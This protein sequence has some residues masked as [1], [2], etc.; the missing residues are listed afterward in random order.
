MPP[1]PAPPE[2][3]ESEKPVHHRR[4]RR[5]WIIIGVIVLALASLLAVRLKER[6]ERSR[7]QKTMME[8]TRLFEK[9]ETE[10]AILL[11]SKMLQK[12]PNNPT[13]LRDLAR[14]FDEFQ[15]WNDSLGLWE[16]LSK[17]PEAT[18]DDRIEYAGALLKSGDDSTARKLLESLPATVR[19]RSRYVEL[20][21]IL[22]QQEG[23]NQE[24]EKLMVEVW[25]RT[26]NE[27][28][29]RL[30]LAQMGFANLPDAVRGDT[31]RILWEFA[32]DIGPLSID[33]LVTL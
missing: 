30:R 24:A 32:R 26:A 18:D 4:H 3:T 14:K 7:N 33:A 5:P 13:V 29:S 19:Q 27:P 16:R 20:Q 11:L 1:D 8:S 2:E 10:R 6:W 22:L 21:A 28:A 23:R 31:A 9:G 17:R 25:Q 15:R 12:A